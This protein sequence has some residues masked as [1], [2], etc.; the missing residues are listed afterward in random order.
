[1][2]PYNMC[3]FLT[4]FFFFFHFFHLGVEVLGPMVTSFN[5]LSNC[6]TF[7]Q[8]SCPILHSHQHHVSVDYFN[9][10]AYTCYSGL[11]DS[12]HLGGW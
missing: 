9:T 4:G 3:S 2:K 7:F 5:H 12:G 10:P 8:S 6:L 11:L 1:M